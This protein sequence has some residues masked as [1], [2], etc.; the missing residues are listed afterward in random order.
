MG[1]PGATPTPTTPP[2]SRLS[3]ATRRRYRRVAL[4]LTV[5]LLAT[6]VLALL[7]GRY[8]RPG[9]MAPRTL[10]ADGLALRILLDL[11][12]PRV[13]AAALLGAVMAG[14]GVAMQMLFANPLVE[15]GLVGVSQGAA[16]GAALTML[17]SGGGAWLTQLGAGLG[18]VVGLG[19]TFSIA[20][21]VRFGGWILR[22]VLAGIAVSAM[23]SAGV[24][25]VKFL[26]DPLEELPAITFWLLGGLWGVS[27]ER[28]LPVLPVMVPGL[29]VLLLM[30]WRLN[31]LSLGDRV[32]FSLGARPGR[33]RALLLLCSTAAVAAGISL[34]GIIG[35]VGLLVPHAA[36]RLVSSDAATSMPVAMLLGAIFMLTADGLARTLVAGEI[37]L[38]VVTS[39]VGAGG[40]LALLS[41]GRVR[42]VR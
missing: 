8:P 2:T 13:V 18:G 7:L 40:F 11:R 32:S 15:P 5:A 36:R 12:L 14:A 42:V 1:T 33:E 28:L 25:L 9:L 6:L 39:L 30:R 27:W 35:W 23:L 4:L 29:V 24:G 41:T 26:A 3:P 34:S 20:R 22:L 19:L 37:P 16:L 38:G 10:T 31:V 21:R 17:A